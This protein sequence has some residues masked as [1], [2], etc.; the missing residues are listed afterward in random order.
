[1]APRSVPSLHSR[2]LAKLLAPPLQHTEP[3]LGSPVPAW[4]IAGPLVPLPLPRGPFSIHS[5]KDLL[6]THVCHPLL[7]TFLGANSRLLRSRTRHGVG[8]LL[9]LSPAWLV[10]Q[11]LTLPLFGDFKPH[12]APRPTLAPLPLWLVGLIPTET[13]ASRRASVAQAPSSPGK[14]GS[15]LPDLRA[16]T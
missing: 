10:P 13:S 12:A 7:F 16:L 3:T 8:R 14:P 5:Q 2:P 11:P 6:E 15:V 9:P 1:M 4:G